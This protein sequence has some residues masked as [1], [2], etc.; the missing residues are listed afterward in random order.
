MNSDAHTDFANAYESALREV[1]LPAFASACDF[2]RQHGL[3]CSVELLEG[4]MQLSELRLTVQGS[5]HQPECYCRITADPRTANLTYESQCGHHADAQRLA[6]P[7]ASLNQM[8]LD[9]RLVQFFQEACGLRLDYAAERHSGG[10][11]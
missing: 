4:E 1:A 9:T 8:V 10:F 2:A 6:A 7:L 3:E 11:W 5:C